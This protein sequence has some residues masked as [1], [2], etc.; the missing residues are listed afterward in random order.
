MY[1]GMGSILRVLWIRVDNLGD[2][3]DQRVNHLVHDCGIVA[4]EYPGDQI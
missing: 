3:P 2:E 4:F 1:V